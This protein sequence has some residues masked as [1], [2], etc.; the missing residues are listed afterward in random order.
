[1]KKPTRLTPPLKCHGGKRYLALD[2]VRLMPHHLSYVEPFAG[3]L[4]VLLARDPKDR[5]LWL[6]T[7]SG[8]KG[9]SEVANDLDCRVMNFWRVLRDEDNFPRFL[10]MAQ[11]TPFAR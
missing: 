11:A 5:R 3:G 8:N 7:G 4:R 9:V 1:M 6:G 2:I 10:R